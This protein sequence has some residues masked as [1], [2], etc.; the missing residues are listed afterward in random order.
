MIVRIYLQERLFRSNP[1]RIGWS[2]SSL[3]S[4]EVIMPRTGRPRKD[5][6]PVVPVRHRARTPDVREQQLTAAAY[7]LAESQ[8]NAGTASAQVITHFLKAG[9]MREQLEQQRLAHENELLIA[10]REAM[11][12]A[13][14]VEELYLGAL[15]AMR[16]YQGQPPLELEG[17]VLD[18]SFD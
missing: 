12:Q 18:D 16:S 9:S 8:I 15:N 1:C 4:E 2:G 10:K 17:E 13:A 3:K 7:D 14:R 5:A 11:A 6:V